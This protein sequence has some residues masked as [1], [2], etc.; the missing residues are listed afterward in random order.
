MD[1]VGMETLP[2]FRLVPTPVGEGADHA[3]KP[4]RP[5][6]VR[7]A[8]DVAFDSATSLPVHDHQQPDLVS[9]DS[10]AVRVAGPP[11]TAL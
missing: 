1:H 9:K 7:A 8:F 5:M 6:P 10:T 4:D 11:A 2:W 3:V